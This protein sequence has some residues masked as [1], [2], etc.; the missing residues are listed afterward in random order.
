MGTL[1]PQMPSSFRGNWVG[2][3]IPRGCRWGLLCWHP[4]AHNPQHLEV[5]WVGTPMPRVLT[6]LEVCWVG[7]LMPEP[8]AFGIALGGHPP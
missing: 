2:T 8:P 3:P 1:M 6:V 5:H 7:T 4:L